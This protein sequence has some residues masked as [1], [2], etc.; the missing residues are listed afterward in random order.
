MF[1][2]IQADAHRKALALHRGYAQS[3][4]TDALRNFAKHIATVIE[5]HLDRVENSRGGVS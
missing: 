5:S 1:W 4:A 2:Q 3:G